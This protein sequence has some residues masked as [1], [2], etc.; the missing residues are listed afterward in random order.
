MTPDSLTATSELALTHEDLRAGLVRAGAGKDERYRLGR[1]MA[2]LDTTGRDALTPDLS[3][4]RDAMAGELA[5]A[6]V[7]AH[8]STIRG[9]YRAILRDNGT[10]ALLHDQAGAWLRELGQADDP[11]NRRALV[12]ERLTRL[13]NDLDPAAAPVDRTTHQDRADSDFLRLTTEQAGLL[14]AAPGVGSRCGLRDTALIG[15]GLCCGLRE[16]EL[17]GLNVA[18]LRQRLGGELALQVRHGKGNKARLIPYGALSWV[19]AI[20]DAWLRSAGLADGPVFRGL[21]KGGKL[22]PGRLSVRGVQDILAGYPVMVDG[23]LRQVRPHDLRR[24]YARLMYSGG[25]DLVAIQQNLGHASLQTTLG[26]IGELDAGKRRP[27]AILTFDLGQLTA[28]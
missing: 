14:L 16:A 13:A 18:D 19:L 20:V 12:D 21:F 1:F 26:Y 6:T 10:R 3:G 22:R 11:A 8:L 4:Y 28:R 24:T 9:R 23:D 25:V 2:W 7:G 5:P 17:C 27:P 15:L